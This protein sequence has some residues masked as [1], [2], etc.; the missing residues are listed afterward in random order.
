[1]QTDYLIERLLAN[2]AS[3]RVLL[4][5]LARYVLPLLLLPIGF[6]LAQMARSWFGLLVGGVCVLV[7]LVQIE[8]FLR[9]IFRRMRIVRY[10]I[11][12]YLSRLPGAAPA[13]WA[14]AL[15]LLLPSALVLVAS[16]ALFLPPILRAAPLWQQ[17]LALAF[18]AGA[19]WSI[20]QRVALLTALIGQVEARLV[21]ARTAHSSAQ[22]RRLLAIEL[23]S[24]TSLERLETQPL[25]QPTLASERVEDGLLD[26]AL[27]RAVAALP[28]PLLPLSPAAQALLRVEAYLLLRDFPDTDDRTLSEAISALAREAHQQELRHWLL[29]TVGGKLYLPIVADGTLAHLLGATARRLGMDG[30]YSATLGT[31]LVRLPPARSYAIAGRLL[32]ALIALRLPPPESILPHHLTIQGDLGQG[33]N[34]LSIVH[35]AATPLIF[36]EQNPHSAGDERPFIMRG[37]GVLDDMGG[38]GRYG[39]PRTDFVDGFVFVQAGLSRVEHL[40]AHTI[41]LRVKQT[42]AFG[43]LSAA[44]PAERRA[45]VEQRAT[46]AY[47]QLRRDLRHFLAGYALEGALELSWLDGHWS[48][49]WPWLRRL[50]Q[51][52]EHDPTFLAGAQRLRDDA[53]DRLEQIAVEGATGAGYKAERLRVEGSR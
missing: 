47:A 22:P 14:A 49:I 28:L 6:G 33:S 20:W 25:P 17:L 10:D 27:M 36:D 38:R 26:P 45:P 7:L 48:E 46:A 12:F 39:G 4:Q 53:L 24:A 15:P 8:L 52:K 21:A 44:R 41:N 31:W 29:P 43:L 3:E 18:S 34:V 35:L 16:M 42:L 11:Q 5:R 32:D 1:M 50:S 51:L 37:G 13:G 19:F 2:V 9:P 23:G 30:G 40:S